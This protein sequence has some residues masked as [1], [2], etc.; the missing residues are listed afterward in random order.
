MGFGGCFW[1]RWLRIH[2]PRQETWVWSLGGEDPLKKGL[3]THSSILVWEIPWTKEPGG[4][5]FMVWQKSDTTEWLT[6]FTF[7]F[8]FL[9]IKEENRE[10]PGQSKPFTYAPTACL[11]PALSSHPHGEMTSRLEWFHSSSFPPGLLLQIDFFWSDHLH[12]FHQEAWGSEII[13]NF[14]M[15]LSKD[16]D[17]HPKKEKP[18]IVN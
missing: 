15:Q 14:Q 17:S 5:Q 10:Q 3:A 6:T 11:L 7:F 16:V 12:R 8:F 18:L 9:G 4:L 1:L 13:C 2:L